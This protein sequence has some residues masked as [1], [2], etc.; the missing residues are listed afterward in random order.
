MIEYP[1]PVRQ[2]LILLFLAVPAAA[3]Q[4]SVTPEMDKLLLEGIDAIYLM[5]F[6]GADAIMDKAVALDPEYPHAYLGRAA[7]DLIRFAYGTQQADPDL[8]KTFQAKTDA[9]IKVAE[10]YL[11]K[12]PKDPDVLFVLGSAHGVSGRLAIVQRQW[13]HAFG[14]G[15]TS[16]KTVRLAAKLDPELYDAQ[17]GLGMFDY[18]VATIPK[19]AGWL[20][21]IVLGGDRARGIRQ[22]KVAAE[23]GHYAKT[24]AQFILVEIFLE[25]RFGARDPGEGLRYMREIHARYPNSPMVDTAFISALYQ[26]KRYDEALKEAREYQARVASG[27]YP[28]AYR[29]QSHLYLGTVLWAA[30]DTPGALGEFNAGAATT[31]GGKLA[32]YAACSRI[33]V[34]QLLDA[35]GRRAEALAAYK[36][37][38]AEKDEWG[39]RALVK[40]CLKAPC[41]SEKFPSQFFPD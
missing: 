41:V 12:H 1:P 21:K 36:A 35:L 40:P 25:D 3:R 5:D 20:A 23:K 7:I 2:L 39:L 4:T 16:M 34:G 24:S 18:Y 11:K 14:H 32:R 31:G 38:Y 33:R 6:D 37:A 10:A 19:F 30:G 29:A 15:R 28:A 27:R 9:A 26:D 8:I 17:L 22:I 13:L